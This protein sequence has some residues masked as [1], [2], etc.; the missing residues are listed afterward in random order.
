MDAARMKLL[1]KDENGLITYEYIANN[2]NSSTI[3]EELDSLVDNI[4]K[5]DR[6]G[7]FVVST[8]RYLNAIDKT[9]YAPQID[10]L[11]KAA[12]EVDRERAYLGT[13]AA[14]IWGDDYKSRAASL[15]ASD[16]NFRRIYKRLYPIGI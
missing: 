5:V 16:D 8:A 7:Q 10:R 1:E 15:I 12:I 14:S 6:T 11:I 4:I 13:L 9:G 2:I 3:V